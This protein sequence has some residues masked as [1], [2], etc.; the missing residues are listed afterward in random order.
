MADVE[1]CF[2]SSTYSRSPRSK[3]EKNGLTEPRFAL[4]TTRLVLMKLVMN[5]GSVAC[6]EWRVKGRCRLKPANQLRQKRRR[7]FSETIGSRESDI[8]NCNRQFTVSMNEELCSKGPE[9]AVTVT[10]ADVD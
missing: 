5:P 10:V 8:S 1:Q 2:S 6:S 9:T 3:N 7:D 4:P